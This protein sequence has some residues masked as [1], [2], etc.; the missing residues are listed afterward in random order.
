MAT[1]FS[2]AASRGAI[3]RCTVCNAGL[4]SLA[5]RLWNSRSMR[6]YRR[7]QRSNACTVFSNV[8]GAAWLAMASTSASC[9]RIACSKAGSKCS[10]RTAANGG[11]P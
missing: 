10:G 5:A 3:S 11:R 1:A 9:S 2:C 7:P 4:V 6:V 8:G